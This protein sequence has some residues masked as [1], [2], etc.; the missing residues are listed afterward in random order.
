MLLVLPHGGSS[1]GSRT[2]KRG[3]ACGVRAWVSQPISAEAA[4]VALGAQTSHPARAGDVV[5][6][7][8]RRTPHHLLRQRV[9]C[10]VRACGCAGRP[11][12]AA[13]T[14]DREPCSR[15]MGSC[16][17][18][19]AGPRTASSIAQHRRSATI[20]VRGAR[21]TDAS[22]RTVRTESSK[23]DAREAPV[24]DRLGGDR[25]CRP[26]GALDLEGAVGDTPRSPRPRRWR[27]RPPLQRAAGPRATSLQP[28]EPFEPERLGRRRLGC[29]S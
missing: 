8:A 20:P 6:R 29:F 15:G 5:T 19:H 10:A 17:H 16:P 23:E 9:P 4:H 27:G 13:A 21:Q 2:P 11:T 3:T 25:R 26:P 22:R 7:S 24:L 28:C 12:V 1:S 14:T 18:L